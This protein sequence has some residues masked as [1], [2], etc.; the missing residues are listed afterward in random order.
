MSKAA[1]HIEQ[2]EGLVT[3]EAVL[4]QDHD[5]DGQNLVED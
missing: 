2:I 3:D 1:Q 5:L 4:K